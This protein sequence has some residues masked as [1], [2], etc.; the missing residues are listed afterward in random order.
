MGEFARVIQPY[1]DAHGIE[2][3]EELA[4]R[5]RTTGVEDRGASEV[6][7][8]MSG[9]PVHAGPGDVLAMERIFGLS[10]EEVSTLQEAFMADV[11]TSWPS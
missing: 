8:W 1:L 9:D 4:R 10:D 5:I 7:Q 6:E 2:G 11:R 3:P